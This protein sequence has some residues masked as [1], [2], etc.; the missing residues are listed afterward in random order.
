M[1]PPLSVVVFLLIGRRVKFAAIV[2]NN[3]LTQPLLEQIAIMAGKG[4]T[5]GLEGLHDEKLRRDLEKARAEVGNQLK[6]EMEQFV[7]T[8]TEL[9]MHRQA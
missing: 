5:Q 6:P 3:L 8:V 1:S 9:E 7:E 4:N 2:T